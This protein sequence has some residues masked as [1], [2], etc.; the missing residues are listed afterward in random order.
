LAP[1]AMRWR[2]LDRVPTWAPGSIKLVHLAGEGACALV[3]K[4]PS[5]RLAGVRGER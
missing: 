3:H 2:L 4:H 5:T 1:A